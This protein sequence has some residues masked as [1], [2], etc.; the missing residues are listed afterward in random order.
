MQLAFKQINRLFIDITNS[1]WHYFNS[2]Q[3][4]YSSCQLFIHFKSITHPQCF[5]A[6]ATLWRNV[7]ECLKL[8]F[9]YMM[10]IKHIHLCQQQTGDLM[11]HLSV[12]FLEM[13]RYFEYLKTNMYSVIVFFKAILVKL[14]LKKNIF[15][16]IYLIA[17]PWTSNMTFV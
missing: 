7:T 14:H 10:V 11:C 17:M 16:P 1:V 3:I 8:L 15:Y 12:L 5:G 4:F 2:V 9:L 6:M 13:I